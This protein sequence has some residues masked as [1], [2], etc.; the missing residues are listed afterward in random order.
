M[1]A[2]ALVVNSSIYDHSHNYNMNGFLDK[3]YT[4]F[5]Q[6]AQQRIA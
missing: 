1:R 4:Q 6:F 5:L 2:A 3:T